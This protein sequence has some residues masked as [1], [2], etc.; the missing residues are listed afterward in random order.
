MRYSKE[1]ICSAMLV[2]M[3][4]MVAGCLLTSCTAE[5]PQD[6]SSDKL[7]IAGFT[8][9]GESSPFEATGG[10]S[11]I[12]LFLWD[13]NDS[14][15]PVTKSGSARYNGAEWKISGFVDGD[16]E[17]NHVYSLYGFG[18]SDAIGS[19]LAVG[20]ETTV[21]TLTD[22][23]AVNEKDV[24]FVVGIQR[25]IDPNDKNIQQGNFS[26]TADV[27]NPIYFLMDH[28]Y[29]SVCFSMAIDADYAK[30]RSIKIKKMELRGTKNTA[31]A[32]ITLR[33][34]ATNT[35]PVQSVT[36]SELAG[37]SRS[38]IFFENPD[39]EDLTTFDATKAKEYICCFLPQL[40]SDLTLVTS[41]D[42]Y[43][44]KGNKISERTVANKLPDLN[45]I[46][47]Q[48]ITM[49]LTVA[50]TYLGVLSDP[51]LDNPTLTFN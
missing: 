43:D 26:F 7:Q 48:R 51:D 49:T 6:L 4:L 19:S 44:R 15:H 37:S 46:R 22:L 24:C 3:L 5:E 29:A 16:V 47:G 30:L 10:Y 2:A 32:T 8:R 20:T 34:N 36:F 28:V 42:V 12:K 41:Y 9:A 25:A 31:T 23:P 39:G 1:H 17:N 33:P 21:L 27:S 13:G 35:D 50:P 14:D 18:P 38:T 11:P 45:A 40:G